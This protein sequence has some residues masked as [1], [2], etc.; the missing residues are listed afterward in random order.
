MCARFAESAQIAT[1]HVPEPGRFRAKRQHG[2]GVTSMRNSRSK[3][4]ARRP[5]GPLPT[6][7]ELPEGPRRLLGDLDPVVYGAMS[8]A[9]A[10]LR[11]QWDVR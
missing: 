11:E 5:R 8:D 4:G 6:V 1:L 3:R 2:R 7:L 10:E 9:P